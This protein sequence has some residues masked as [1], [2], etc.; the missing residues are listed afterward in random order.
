MVI[1]LHGRAARN[2]I[3]NRGAQRRRRSTAART[4]SAVAAGTGPQ[5]NQ[6]VSKPATVT[7]TLSNPRPPHHKPPHHKPPHQKSYGQDG[8]DSLE[9]L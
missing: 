8:T 9:Q 4:F 5:G 6:I 3:W 2:S 1:L 7:I